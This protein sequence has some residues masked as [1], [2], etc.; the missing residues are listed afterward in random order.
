MVAI[1]ARLV[2][3]ESLVAP[4]P[5][6]VGNAARAAMAERFWVWCPTSD[7]VDDRTREHRSRRV[8]TDND[9]VVS[10]LY[11]LD[12]N[13]QTTSWVL[14]SVIES[15]II[16]ALLNPTW[17]HSLITGSAGR[18]DL[19]YDGSEREIDGEHIRTDITLTCRLWVATGG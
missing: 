15:R 4:K 7:A 3:E 6:T 1:Q 10:V 19:F 18:F 13:D 11:P 12:P 2:S 8:Q 14:A 5:I 17:Q 9:V 16:D